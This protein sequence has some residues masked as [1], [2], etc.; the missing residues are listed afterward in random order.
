MFF[1]KVKN[2][3]FYVFYLQINDFNI[4][5]LSGPDYVAAYVWFCLVQCSVASWQ[6]GGRQDAI[7]P[8]KFF[9]L[10]E[11]YQG[12]FLPKNFRPKMQKM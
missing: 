1:I 5:G 11:N 12:I 4:Y 9:W 7:A 2:V 8:P 10:L 3:F 6:E